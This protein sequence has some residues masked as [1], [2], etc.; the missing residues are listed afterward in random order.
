MCIRDRNDG[1]VK[2]LATGTG[3]YNE[4]KV[5]KDVKSFEKDKKYYIKW[6]KVENQKQEVANKLAEL[7]TALD[8][9]DKAVSKYA[10]K[11]YGTGDDQAN[12]A[13]WYYFAYNAAKDSIKDVNSKGDAP[14]SYTHLDVYKR[15][16]EKW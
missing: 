13:Q 5:A 3:G 16:Q 11:N 8:N 12:K 4:K 10:D 2:N 14:V 1:I 9:A 15:Q 7:E 6:S